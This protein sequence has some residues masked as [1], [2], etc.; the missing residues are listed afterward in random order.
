MVIE[1]TSEVTEFT[2][3]VTVMMLAVKFPTSLGKF[4][5][6]VLDV[7]TSLE[8]SSDLGDLTSE[9]TELASTFTRPMFALFVA[10]RFVATPVDTSLADLLN[11]I[12]YFTLKNVLDICYVIY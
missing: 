7:I 5:T 9:V 6:R 10:A 1:M 11:Q 4:L 3:D 2:S 8:M 12:F